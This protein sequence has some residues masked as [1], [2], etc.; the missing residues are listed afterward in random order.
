MLRPGAR[1]RVAAVAS[2]LEAVQHIVEG[3]SR[4][5]RPLVRRQREIIRHPPLAMKPRVEITDEDNGVTLC[6]LRL[7]H[8]RLQDPQ[9][10]L[11]GAAEAHVGVQG[12]IP[13]SG[14]GPGG[15]EPQEVHDFSALHSGV[16]VDAAPAGPLI[17]FLEVLARAAAVRLWHDLPLRPRVHERVQDGVVMAAG[18]APEA[19]IEGHRLEHDVHVVDLE[20]QLGLWQ[21]VV[22]VCDDVGAPR[23]ALAALPPGHLRVQ[24]VQHLCQLGPLQ[25]YLP[26]PGV[27]LLRVCTLRPVQHVQ[28]VR[29]V[30]PPQR[31]QELDPGGHLLLGMLHAVQL[32]EKSIDISRSLVRVL[33]VGEPR[34]DIINAIERAFRPL[35]HRLHHLL[36]AIDVDREQRCI[37]CRMLLLEVRLQ[38]SLL[39]DDLLGR[40]GDA[41]DFPVQLAQPALRRAPPE[42]A[43]GE[44]GE[45]VVLVAELLQAEDD[46]VGVLVSPGQFRQQLFEPSVLPLEPLVTRVERGRV[47]PQ[48]RLLRSLRSVLVKASSSSENM[49]IVPE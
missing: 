29:D 9:P 4:S 14:V 34:P 7:V 43:L 31:A 13:Q 33:Q 19:R 23:R 40:G 18:G 41:Q 5:R 20:A 11:R 15:L 25:H 36:D 24:F 22:H 47:H 30:A 3:A 49:N 26:V 38:G 44:A 46:E 35:L 10:L 12:A 32:V 1:Q 37:E 8:R 2:P 28:R 45:A 27:H 39:A 48:A 17:V 6:R 42:G 16:V 21:E